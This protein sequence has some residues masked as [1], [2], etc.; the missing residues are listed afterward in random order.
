MIS[1]F[2]FLIQRAFYR[3]DRVASTGMCFYSGIDGVLCIQRMIHRWVCQWSYTAIGCLHS[4]EK[5]NYEVFR[6]SYFLYTQSRNQFLW[7]QCLNIGIQELNFVF[8]IVGSSFVWYVQFSG[9]HYLRFVDP[10][11]VLLDVFE[12]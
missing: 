10:N 3:F 12:N 2:L 5:K 8:A 11:P 1:S 7:S 9:I 6:Y 4:I